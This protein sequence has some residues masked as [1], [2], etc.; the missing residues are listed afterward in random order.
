[1]API[2][3][4]NRCP[5][6]PDNVASKEVEAADGVVRICS[7]DPAVRFGA[8]VCDLGRFIPIHDDKPSALAA[9]ARQETAG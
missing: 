3:V 5:L 1:L 4:S 2:K 8:D 9:F 6:D 7:M